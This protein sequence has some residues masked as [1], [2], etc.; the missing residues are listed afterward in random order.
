MH[1]MPENKYLSLLFVFFRGLR[2]DVDLLVACNLGILV[3][4]GFLTKLA[5]NK[6]TIL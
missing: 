3:G 1:G 4:T 2:A 6:G 5:A